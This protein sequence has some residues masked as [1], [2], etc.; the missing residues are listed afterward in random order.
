MGYTIGE[1]TMFMRNQHDGT[2]PVQDIKLLFFK[3]DY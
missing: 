2:K 3:M 1:Q